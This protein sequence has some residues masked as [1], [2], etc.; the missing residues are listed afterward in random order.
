MCVVCIYLY[1]YNVHHVQCTCMYSIHSFSHPPTHQV[2][3]I[4]RG[5]CSAIALDRDSSHI[6]TAGDNS[7]KVWDYSMALDLN[8]Q[9]FVGH[10]EPVSQLLLSPDGSR[11]ISSADAVFFWDYLAPSPPSPPSLPSPPPHNNSLFSVSPRTGPPAPTNFEPL[12]N[13]V[14]TPQPPVTDKVGSRGR[15][16]TFKNVPQDDSSAEGKGG[17]REGEG[18][19]VEGEGVEGGCDV[20]D[21]SSV[22]SSD[23]GADVICNNTSCESGEI[24]IEHVSP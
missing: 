20:R 23:D 3:H 8:F 6:L 5:H 10:S 21:E 15:V 17:E 2:S 12:K 18:E 22:E 13:H 24:V 4:H 19:G 14:F 9:V 7:I 11:V 1:M 16:P